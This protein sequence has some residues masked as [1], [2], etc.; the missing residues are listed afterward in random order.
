MSYTFVC[1]F[2]IPKTWCGLKS[3]PDGLEFPL[4][5][6]FVYTSAIPKKYLKLPQSHH[7]GPFGKPNQLYIKA[8]FFWKHHAVG[9][10]CYSEQQVFTI[11][12]LIYAVHFLDTW[13][14][15]SMKAIQ[16]AQLTFKIWLFSDRKMTLCIIQITKLAVKVAE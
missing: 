3:I 11:H 9:D 1:L 5:Y 4:P 2:G 16:S 7:Q 15:Y 14:A 6:T 8:Q 10:W 12:L 13:H